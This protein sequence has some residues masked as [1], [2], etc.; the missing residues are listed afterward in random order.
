VEH[1]VVARSI[2]EDRLKFIYLCPESFTHFGKLME[3]LI[4]KALI[5]VFVVDEAHLITTCEFRPCYRELPSQIPNDVK[6]MMLSGTIH[7]NCTPGL[8]KSIC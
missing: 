3:H 6:L 1:A 8:K 2:S 5:G 7:D 4:E